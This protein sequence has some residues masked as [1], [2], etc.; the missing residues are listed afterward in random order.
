MATCTTTWSS[1]SLAFYDEVAR[2]VAHTGA[3]FLRTRGFVAFERQVPAVVG[4]TIAWSD[5]NHLSG[6]Y[7]A[8]LGD[9]F[10]AALAQALRE[11]R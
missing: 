6:A 11:R 8:S 4:R 10:G 5:T 1:G 3:G 9:A 2:R 7:S